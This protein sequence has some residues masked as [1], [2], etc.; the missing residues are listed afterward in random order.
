MAR[1]TIS[2]IHSPD[3]ARN[4]L[5]LP[6][7]PGGHGAEPRVQQ[8]VVPLSYWDKQAAMNAPAPEV[9]E[10]DKLASALRL[11]ALEAVHGNRH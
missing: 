9:D 2:G 4:D 3:E 8:Q 7:V 1:S 5:D 10:T 6:V 11:K